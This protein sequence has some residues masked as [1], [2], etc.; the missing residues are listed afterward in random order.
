[1]GS[2]DTEIR[3]STKVETSQ[4][5]KLQIQIDKAC[6]KV[7]T[8]TKEYDELRNKKIPTQGYTD[9]ENKIKSVKFVLNSLLDEQKKLSDKGSG[10]GGAEGTCC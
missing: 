3:V 6:R 2:Y 9:L 10:K 1:M 8:L 7:E 5:Q 4:M